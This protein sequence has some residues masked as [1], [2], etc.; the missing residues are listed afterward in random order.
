MLTVVKVRWSPALLLVRK[1]ALKRTINFSQP[2]HSVTRGVNQRRARN[3]DNDS[4]FRF[5]RFSDTDLSISLAAGRSGARL[6]AY[7]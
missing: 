7:E 4:R 5:R 6:S 3:V 2:G 1:L